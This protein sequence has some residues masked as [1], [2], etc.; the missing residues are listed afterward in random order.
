MASGTRLRGAGLRKTAKPKSAGVFSRGLELQGGSAGESRL[1][2]EQLHSIQHL[3]ESHPAVN[4]ARTVLHG[5][6]L[7]G[8]VSLKKDG[9]E[10]E[11]TEQFRR[12]L[13]DFWMPFASD[14]I[15]S[16]CSREPVSM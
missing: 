9:K 6:L 5:Q 12:H 3:F 7:S 10:V 13:D 14:V 1:N 4:A 2:L 15:D 11:L 8:G 16:S